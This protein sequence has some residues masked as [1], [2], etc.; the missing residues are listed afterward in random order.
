MPGSGKIFNSAIKM[1]TLKLELIMVKINMNY[2]IKLK[3]KSRD[4]FILL[5]EKNKQLISLTN[6]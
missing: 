5:V 2:S 4:L 3:N 1:T 6:I